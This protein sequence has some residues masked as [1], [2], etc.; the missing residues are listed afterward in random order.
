MVGFALE[1]EQE[2]DNAL[3]KLKRKNLD[4]I[5]LNSLNDP[6]AGFG[7]DT[8]KVTVFSAD[9]SV[10]EF[11]TQSKKEIARSLVS[12]VVRSIKS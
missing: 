3:S 2:R 10:N 11:D 1:T 4:H 6:G 5:V 12:L 9:G 8:N 7:H